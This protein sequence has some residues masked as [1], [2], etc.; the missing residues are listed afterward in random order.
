[1]AW[2]NEGTIPAHNG[3]RLLLNR[4][5]FLQKQMTEK[6]SGFT[7]MELVAVII[8]LG[9]LSAIAVPRFIDLMNEALDGSVQGIAG[10][11]APRLPSIT[12]P[13]PPI[14]PRT[15]CSV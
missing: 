4:V 11:L 8:M 9:I 2:P 1:V 10:A 13:S 14:R 5:Q 7:M 12:Q 15:A 6:S 3:V